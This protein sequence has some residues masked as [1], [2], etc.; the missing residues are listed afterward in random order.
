MG[1]DFF[2]RGPETA[3]DAQRSPGQRYRQHGTTANRRTRPETYL[4][5]R[6][7]GR[8]RSGGL[9][10]SLTQMSIRFGVNFFDSRHRVR[11]LAFFRFPF[12]NVFQGATIGT[13][14]LQRFYRA[15]IRNDR[16]SNKE[17]VCNHEK[18]TPS[19]RISDFSHPFLLSN[20]TISISVQ[21]PNKVSIISTEKSENGYSKR[22]ARHITS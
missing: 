17:L 20:L 1:L 22:E 16:L 15:F 19:L 14:L 7:C 13:S 18:V 3:L 12:E 2:L 6:T 11:F 21:F 8:C 5:C 10:L 4:G 9:S